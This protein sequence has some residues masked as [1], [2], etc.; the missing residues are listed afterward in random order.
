ML[1]D[2]AQAL[3]LALSGNTLM[4]KISQEL[5]DLLHDMVYLL[6]VQLKTPFIVRT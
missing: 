5:A 6:A 1:L 3:T 4:I 2:F